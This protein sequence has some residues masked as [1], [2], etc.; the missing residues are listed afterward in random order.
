MASYL[1]D[2]GMVPH[3]YNQH[4]HF[5]ARVAVLLDDSYL[6]ISAIT[7]GEIEFGHAITHSTDLEQRAAIDRFVRSQFP[8]TFTIPVT[9]HTAMHYGVLKA[10]LFRQNPPASRRENHPERCI[11]RVTGAE[12]GIDEND[13]WIAA[14]AI[15]HNLVL[16]TNDEMLRIREAAGAAGNALDVEDWTQPI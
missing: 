13:L 9:R 3:Y 10:E 4:P 2:T 16:V 7:L 6:F 8:L 12:L 14:Q 15:E 5:A 11:D 1:L